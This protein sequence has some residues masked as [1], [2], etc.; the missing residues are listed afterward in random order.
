R[1]G[2]RYADRA[3]G[4]PHRRRRHLDGRLRRVPSGRTKAP[5][6]RWGPSCVV[7][8]SAADDAAQVGR[9]RLLVAALRRDLDLE[10]GL[11]PADLEDPGA[12]LA[13]A[14]DLDLLEDLEAPTRDAAEELDL[15]V[16][17]GDLALDVEV[18]GAA[19]TALGG[20]IVL[21]LR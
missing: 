21:R 15:A 12:E 5:T 10:A 7:P 18:V 17:G 4:R 8:R 9:R 19:L 11:L 6:A 3:A 1:R 16:E 20:D 14:L 2:H 13:A